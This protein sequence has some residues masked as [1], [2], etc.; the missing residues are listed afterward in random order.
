MMSPRP[1]TPDSVAG[2]AP[3]FS[4]SQRISVH[5][6]RVAEGRELRQSGTGS[7]SPG[8][9][10]AHLRDQGGQGVVSQVHPVTDASGDGQDVLEGAGCMR[11]GAAAQD[12]CSRGSRPPPSPSPARTN[13]HADDIRCGV[14][15]HVVA[16]EQVL[17]PP[18]HIPI[19][20]RD[21]DGSGPALHDLLG[22]RGPREEG[23]RVLSAQALAH[24]L[25]HHGAGGNLQALAHTDD[26]D[27]AGQVLLDGQQKGAAGLHG[28]RVHRILGAADGLLRIGGRPHVLGQ[29]EVLEVPAR[30]GPFPT[31]RSAPAGH[32]LPLGSEP[33]ASSRWSE[34]H[35]PTPPAWLARISAD[36]VLHR[37]SLMSLQR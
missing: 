2:L 19:P 20:G 36:L 17:E 32:V 4:A 29:A 34:L 15:P 37:L 26:R 25:A 14:H 30:E 13:L 11:T 22:E 18:R 3:I 7:C 1:E 24:H 27:A 21:D 28:N 8:P 23:G 31:Q 35:V 33:V 6:W 16:R 5:P 10:Q 9:Q 12:R